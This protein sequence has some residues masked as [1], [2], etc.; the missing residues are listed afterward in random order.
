MP[1][2]RKPD[3]RFVRH[4]VQPR[5]KYLDKRQ[6]RLCRI[7]PA[8][9][10]ALRVR[11]SN[12]DRWRA[13]LD[14]TAY[15][16][17]RS[18]ERCHSPRRRVYNGACY[19]CMLNRNKGDFHLLRQGVMPPANNTR[20][21]WLDRLERINREQSGECSRYEIGQYVAEQ[22]PTGRVRLIAPHLHIDNHDMKAMQPQR[23][24]Q[25]A[26]DDPDFLLLLRHLG[27]A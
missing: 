21:G 8:F 24:Y 14:G 15:F 25:L 4:G 6:Y 13:F 11:V 26:L 17:G 1:L 2:R 23:V 12:T 19:D 7:D 3:Q 22:F 18:C 10:E 20:D 5:G 27:W 16:F 9:K